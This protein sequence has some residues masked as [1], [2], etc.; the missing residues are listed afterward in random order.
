MTALV[1]AALL[2]G[3]GG[4][5]QSTAPGG[6]PVQPAR[7]SAAAT[8]ETPVSSAKTSSSEA[9]DSE[10]RGNAGKKPKASS[11]SDG[12]PSATREVKTPRS[13]GAGR[14]AVSGARVE[15]ALKK[16]RQTLSPS[17]SGGE[18]EGGGK[19]VLGNAPS[20]IAEAGQGDGGE[21]IHAA[22]E[23]ALEQLREQQR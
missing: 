1:A 3:C 22:T 12:Q 23:K 20:Q 19:D 15:Q 14:Q 11:G 18:A 17:S 9:G 21:D 16:T 2:T 8:S 4:G 6:E 10:A 13:S 7:P 5:T